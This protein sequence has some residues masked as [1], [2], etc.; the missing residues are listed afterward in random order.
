M[1][2]KDYTESTQYVAT[3]SSSGDRAVPCNP[4]SCLAQVAN[5]AMATADNRHVLSHSGVMITF[6]ELKKIRT[7]DYCT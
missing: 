4:R 3:V 7:Q 6:K 5:D 1:K 2:G